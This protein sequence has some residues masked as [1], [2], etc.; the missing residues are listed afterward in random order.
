MSLTVWREFMSDTTRSECFSDDLACSE[1]PH[2]AD[3]LLALFEDLEGNL[4][5]SQRALVS[6]DLNQL[7]ECTREQ[8]L[9]ARRLADLLDSAAVAPPGRASSSEMR[10]EV[11]A[12]QLRIL[13]LG[14]VHL[15]LLA[16]RKQGLRTLC[17]RIAGPHSLYCP[18]A[19]S[20]VSQAEQNRMRAKEASRKPCQA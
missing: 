11:R 1:L 10:R 14:R 8:A 15:A 20:L 12:A 16:R 19:A 9:L 17:H 6:G 18:P 7:E 13:H 3:M 4:L 5:A 2:A